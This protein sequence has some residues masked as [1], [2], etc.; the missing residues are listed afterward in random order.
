MFWGIQKILLYAYFVLCILSC[1]NKHTVD[2]DFKNKAQEAFEF[3]KKNGLDTNTAILVNFA[4][5]SGKN[6]LVV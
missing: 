4:I 6:R 5:P 3:C 1:N 2:F